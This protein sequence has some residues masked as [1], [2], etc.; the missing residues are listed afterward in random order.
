VILHEARGFTIG[1]VIGAGAS[2]AVQTGV[3]REHLVD[4]VL[5]VVLPDPDDGEE[6]PWAWLA[7]LARFRGLRVAADEL[8]GV[9]YEVVLTDSLTRW[10]DAS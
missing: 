6:H 3:T 8:R 2:V 5:A 7:H 4:T 9:P 10:L 1:P